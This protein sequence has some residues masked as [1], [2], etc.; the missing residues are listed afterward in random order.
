MISQDRW[1]EIEPYIDQALELTSSTRKAYVA[2]LRRRDAALADE[3]ARFVAECDQPDP[4]LDDSAPARFGYL[5]DDVAPAPLPAHALLAGRYRI[6]REIGRG[7]MAIVYLARDAK[8]HDRAVAVKVMRCSSLTSHST[9]RF[10]DEIRVT[11]TLRH[12]NIVPVYDADEFEDEAFFVMPHIEGETLRD[13]LAREPTARLPISDA[14]RIG[15]D[16]A[17]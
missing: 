14:L 12:P 13:R 11:G 15:I 9:R 10:L 16:I 2:E 8:L 6:E 1:L 3:V 4:R 5:L 7:G 17:R